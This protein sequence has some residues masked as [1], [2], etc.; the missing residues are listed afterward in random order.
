MK[1]ALQYEKK[2]ARIEIDLPMLPQLRVS[3]TI[4]EILLDAKGGGESWQ[5]FALR[6][7]LVLALLPDTLGLRLRK[8]QA[9]TVRIEIGLPQL[10]L[11]PAILEILEDAKGEVESWSWFALRGMLVLSLLPDTL[12][13]RLRKVHG[14]VV[15]MVG[16]ISGPTGDLSGGAAAAGEQF[17]GPD[18]CQG[19]SGRPPVVRA[20]RGWR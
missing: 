10:R 8:V 11:T 12:C 1:N 5:S 9:Q 7:M 18:R 6:G 13:L 2:T 19:G 20:S 4:R 16:E 17:G 3:P 14:Q 15:R